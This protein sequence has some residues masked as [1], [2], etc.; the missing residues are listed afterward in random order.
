[1]GSR[2]SGT[3]FKIHALGQGD[4]GTREQLPITHYPLPQLTARYSRS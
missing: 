2:E 1:M 3:K 4:K